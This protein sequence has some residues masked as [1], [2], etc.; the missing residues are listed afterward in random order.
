MMK[1]I[2]H[3]TICLVV[4]TLVAGVCLAFVNQITADPIAKA[5]A[6]ERA[7]SY[8]KVF[9]EAA[10]FSEIADTSALCDRISSD[11]AT[12]VSINQALTAVDGNGTP[13]GCV[14][15]VT[16]ANG[17]G[18]D[19]VMSLGVSGDGTITGFTVT[20][21]SETPSLGAYCTEDWFSEQFKGINAPAIRYTKDGKSEPDQ[22]D[23]ITGATKT[24]KAVTE[25]VNGGLRFAQEYF[26]TLIQVTKDGG[27]ENE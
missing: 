15:S 17:Y 26:T 2:I 6:E 7:A 14:V 11:L 3:D 18:G 5:E 23:A 12:G 20:S 24:T 13:L 16:S 8:R 4:I 9:P 27:A 21:M 19:I 25:A 10:D 1:K 22:I